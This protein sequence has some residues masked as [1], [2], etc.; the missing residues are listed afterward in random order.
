MARN[1]K[2]Y[3]KRLKEQIVERANQGDSPSDLGREFGVNPANIFR[4]IKEFKAKGKELDKV[5][6]DNN[7]VNKLHHGLEVIEERPT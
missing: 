5:L 7:F 2:K 4:W 6:F 3:S 1:R